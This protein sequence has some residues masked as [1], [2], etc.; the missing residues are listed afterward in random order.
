L[1]QGGTFFLF[2]KLRTTNR[3]IIHYRIGFCFLNTKN[4]R[5]VFWGLESV[6][7]MAA[8]KRNS[9][10]SISRRAQQG[11][12]LSAQRIAKAATKLDSFWPTTG[13]AVA[14]EH[15]RQDNIHHDV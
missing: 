9:Y 5:I 10:I 1:A 8:W 15:D 4:R 12:A 6:H 3:F 7:T 14:F 11:R 2:R 13:V